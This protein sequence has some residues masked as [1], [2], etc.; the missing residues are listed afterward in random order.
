MVAGRRMK[1]SIYSAKNTKPCFET[2]VRGREMYK[3]TSK[4]VSFAFG[5]IEVLISPKK[6]M[7]TLQKYDKFSFFEK[8]LPE[9]LIF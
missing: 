5:P 2:K 1:N 4:S 3:I 6:D 8:S 9:K 7:L